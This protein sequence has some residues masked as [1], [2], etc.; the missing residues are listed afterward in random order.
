M[1]RHRGL[2]AAAVLTLGLAL[3]GC[4]TSDLLDKLSDL[5]IMSTP[6]RPLQGERRVVF[7]AGTPGVPQGVPPELIKGYQAADANQPEPTKQVVAPPERPKPKKKVAVAPKPAK[8]PK[9]AADPVNAPWTAP[10]PSPQQQ[11]GPNAP[12]PA[13]QQQPQVAWPDPPP[14]PRR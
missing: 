11:T 2:L 12:W 8:Q 1:M 13:P 10:P 7:P 4:E 9:Q 3:A 14:P 6:K 5:D